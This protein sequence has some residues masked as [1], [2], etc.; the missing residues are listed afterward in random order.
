MFADKHTHT[1]THTHMHTNEQKS[2]KRPWFAHDR[3]V[4]SGL[5]ACPVASANR[6]EE[7]VNWAA[8]TTVGPASALPRQQE[9]CAA[10]SKQPSPW[11]LLSVGCVFKHKLP[12]TV[13][14]SPLSHRH[15]VFNKWQDF[16][17]SALC[18]ARCHVHFN[19]QIVIVKI[20]I[21]IQCAD[22]QCKCISLVLWP[23]CC[24][25]IPLAR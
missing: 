10:S 19:M 6:D 4:C 15:S 17:P 5:P 25:I 8:A 2:V 21:L 14:Y 22:L 12:L 16:C 3:Q 20:P 13:C 24:Q 1:H 7:M 23:F 9:I 18:S 11:Q